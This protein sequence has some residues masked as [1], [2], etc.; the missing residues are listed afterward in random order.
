M[1][2]TDVGDSV[3]RTL[4]GAKWKPRILACL[5]REGRL[6]FADLQSA[7]DGVS[8][9]VLSENLQEL[10]AHDVL[11]KD[12]VG[13]RP[14]RV[15]YELTTAG[16]ELYAIVNEMLAWDEQY[17]AGE[18]RP[19]VLLAEDDPRQLELYALWLSPTY[20]V[21]TTTDGREALTRLDESIDA[22]V[23]DR[24]LPVLD[25]E[26]V[27]RSLDAASQYVPTA[28]LSS[29]QVRPDDVSLPVDV[30]LS[31]PIPR[32]ELTSAVAE[33]LRFRDLS[34]AA[35]EVRGR[36]HRLRFI[37]A[38]LGSAVEETEQYTAAVA[39][40]ERLETE[41]E[42]ELRACEPWRRLVGAAGTAG[43]GA[44]DDVSG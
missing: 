8:N 33:L 37:R 41:R 28:I 35:R 26:S 30:L 27:A 2:D 12:V 5:H 11:T 9:K 3:A 16:E 24:R 19:T 1:T 44:G 25:G 34:P 32:E 17:A 43:G 18:G 7:L 36:R 20:D 6:G 10:V 22:A 13:T 38:E 29:E 42:L 39:E 23:L 14:T 31:K 15:E 21:V 40:V 4:L